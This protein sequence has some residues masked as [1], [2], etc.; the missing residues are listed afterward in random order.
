MEAHRNTHMCVY[1]ALLGSKLCGVH[2]FG[3]MKCFIVITLLIESSVVVI[4]I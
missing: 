3:K 1:K 2:A 4:I